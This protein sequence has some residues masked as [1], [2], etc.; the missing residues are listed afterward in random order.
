MPV[1][2]ATDEQKAEARERFTKG[3]EAFGAK[4]YE[5]ALTELRASYD[6]VASPNSRILIVQTL[7][8]MGRTA[9]AYEEVEAV[10][11]QAEAAAA[12]DPKYE[13]TA[14]AARD[15]R[16][17]IRPAIGMVQVNVPAGLTTGTLTVNGRVIPSERWEQPVA[18]KPGVVTVEFSGEEPKEVTVEAGGQ[19]SVDLTP[20]PE[21]EPP[22]PP[23]PEPDKGFHI[24]NKRTIAYISGG[25]GAAGMLMFAIFGGLASSTYSDLEE[26]CPAKVGCDPALEEDADSG[27][28][29]Q[30]VANV[31]LVI[32]IVGLAAGAGFFVWDLLDPDEEEGAGDA[33]PAAGDD[34]FEDYDEMARIRP[35][36]V[37]GPGS[38]ML[39]GRF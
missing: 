20:A 19:V 17:A 6:I 12:A 8:A 4:D 11:A 14:K 34:E 25:V 37:F 1:E 31:S 16:D 39:R 5:T 32:G 35:Q 38:V 15:L 26:S 27:Q 29:Y 7:D 21:P 9:E 36:I 23:E 24:K 2:Q 3:K 18:V 22:P 13:Q 30:T 10:V 33:G 28:T